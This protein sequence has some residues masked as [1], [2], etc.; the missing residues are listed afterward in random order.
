MPYYS[1]ML[2]LIETPSF[3]R[4]WPDY[5]TEEERAEFAV[6]LAHNPETGDV[7][8]GTGGVRKVRWARK[9]TGKSGGVRVI[10]FN[11]LRAGEIWLLLIYSKSVAENIPAHI[12]RQVKEELEN[13][14]ESK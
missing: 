13:G 5:W 14:Q 6:W 8:P 4:L 3:Q 1:A 7:V 2:T 9:G 11:R 10:Y 12:L